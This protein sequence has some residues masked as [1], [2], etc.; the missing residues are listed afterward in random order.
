MSVYEKLKNL[1][2][3][4]A[5]TRSEDSAPTNYLDD[6]KLSELRTVAKERGLRGYTKL[7][8]ADLLQLL[9]EE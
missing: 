8:K 5:P 2:R 4:R 1:F 6:L 7:R 3:K 9:K